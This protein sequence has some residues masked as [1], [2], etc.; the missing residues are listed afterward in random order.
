MD[1]YNRGIRKV[2]ACVGDTPK[3]RT[4]DGPWVGSSDTDGGGWGNG[5]VQWIAARSG[6]EG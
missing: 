5:P 4:R 3:L 1:E 2:T 6:E